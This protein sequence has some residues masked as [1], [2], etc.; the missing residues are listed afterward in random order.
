[1]KNVILNT[2]FAKVYAREIIFFV[3]FTK[4]N[5]LN[6]VIFQPHESFS[7]RKFVHLKY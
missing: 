4:V 6:F 3:K 2:Q 7:T 1:M 5:V